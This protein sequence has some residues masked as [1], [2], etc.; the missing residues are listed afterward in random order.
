MARIRFLRNA[1]G[2][3]LRPLMPPQDWIGSA[4]DLVDDFTNMHDL[5][6][7]TDH[8]SPRDFAGPVDGRRD[9]PYSCLRG[10]GVSPVISALSA[11]YGAVFA[12]ALFREGRV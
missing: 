8:D 12:S 9:Q 6:V 11:K 2:P 3:V 5:A 1:L 7:T 4:A 10:A